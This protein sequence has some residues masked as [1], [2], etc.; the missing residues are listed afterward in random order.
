[1]APVKLLA[2]RGDLAAHRA[3]GADGYVVTHTRSGLALDGF[4]RK[5]S[6]ARLVEELG[7]RASMLIGRQSRGDERARKTVTRIRSAES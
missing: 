5:E 7:D 6:A 1:M 2:Q 3:E 4:K